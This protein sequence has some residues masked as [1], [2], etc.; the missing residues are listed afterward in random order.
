MDRKWKRQR[1]CRYSWGNFR[2]SFIDL[3]VSGWILQSTHAWKPF[4]FSNQ[5]G[6]VSVVS[7]YVWFSSVV[8][9]VFISRFLVDVK[10]LR[11]SLQVEALQD[12]AQ[13]MLYDYVNNQKLLKTRFGRLLLQLPAL[14]NMSS[15]AVEDIF[16][17]RTIGNIPIERILCDMFKSS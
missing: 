10:G 9:V 14:R 12:Q 7:F 1:W 13:I 5:V 15:R 2:T 11:D 17:R 8:L 16:F 3:T 6:F 4:S